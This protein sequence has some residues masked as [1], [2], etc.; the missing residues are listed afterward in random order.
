MNVSRKNL[1]EAAALEEINTIIQTLTEKELY[2][3][4]A[5]CKKKISKTENKEIMNLKL[6]VTYLPRRKNKKLIQAIRRR[7][8]IMNWERE[9]VTKRKRRKLEV[10]KLLNEMKND[11][12][13]MELDNVTMEAVFA[14]K[15]SYENFAEGFE[16]EEL[17]SY[18]YGYLKL[19]VSIINI[20]DTEAFEEGEDNAIKGVYFIDR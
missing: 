2:E 14:G 17:I 18:A 13:C 10:L 15:S 8:C 6:L 16:I 12:K 9:K 11:L 7:L 5:F 19:G 20:Y 4:L 1:I 3:A